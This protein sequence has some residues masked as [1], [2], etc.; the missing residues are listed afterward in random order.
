MAKGQVKVEVFSER[1]RLRWSY[2]GQRYCLSIGLP[3]SIIN[4]KVATQKAQQIELDMLSDNFDPSLSK[5]RSD[6]TPSVTA[7]RVGQTPSAF[8]TIFE[9]HWDAFVEDKA[10]RI[11]SPFTIVGMYN[12]IPNKVKDYG[13]PIIGSREAQD[14][15][16]FMLRSASPTT[17][18]K[19]VIIL[20][21]FGNWVQHHKLVDAEWENPFTGLTEMCRPVPPT[22]VPP[23]SK[24]EI[25]QI[26]EAFRHDRYYAHY[27]NYVR[28]LFMTGCRTSEAIGLQWKHIRHDCSEITF[29]ETLV[30]KGTGSARIRK[31]TKTNRSRTFPC[32]GDLQELLM[33]VRPDDYKPE[34]LVFPSPKGKP[35]DGNNFVK[36]AW[37]K[38]L[39]KC[40]MTKEN[41]LYRT[42]YNTRH[43]FISHMLA[44]GMSVIEVARLTGHDPKILLEHYAGLICKI[45]VPT[46]F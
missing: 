30:R 20:N 5:Y 7:R 14:F 1:L 33:S 41:G 15:V 4:R 24:S 6:S 32:N 34:M 35:I 23:F 44:M 10:Q 11:D 9:Q 17:I 18:K 13:R 26:I 19:Q 40:G 16:T 29:N 21:D 28:F 3:D 27:T 31:A 12:P 22:K 37:V 2:R 36:R 46:F 39:K 43:T 45:E 42:Q 25:E 38:I 8:S